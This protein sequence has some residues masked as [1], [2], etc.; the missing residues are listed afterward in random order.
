M[1]YLD[2]KDYLL[3]KELMENSRAPLTLLG[4]KLG[5]TDVAVKKRLKK[6]EK[7]G[8][9][10]KYTIEVDASKLGYKNV[11]LIGVDTEPEK[12][13][14]VAS[15]LSQKDYASKVF[16]TTGDHMIMIEAWTKDNKHLTQVVED[17]GK[18]PGVKRVC[19]AI[20]LEKIK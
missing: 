10:K 8:V 5:M 19:P 7:E 15:Q 12:I 13:L 1:N 14:E 11:A 2:E 17:I 3:V 18:I 9:I 4:K 6:L 20:V 16:L